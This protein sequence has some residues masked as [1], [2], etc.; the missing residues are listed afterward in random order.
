MISSSGGGIMPNQDVENYTDEDYI[1][2][3]R[4]IGWQYNLLYNNVPIVQNGNLLTNAS[5][6]YINEYVDNLTYIYGMQVPA[7]YKFFTM[8]ANGNDLQTPLVRGLDVYKI[9]NYLLG[10]GKDIID[11]LPKTLN[12]SAYSKGAISAKKDMMD[13]IKFQIENKAFLKIL[14][15][16]AG[17]DFKA[18]NRDFEN[19]EQVEKFFTDFQESM[20]IAYEQIA[21]HTVY[22]NDYKEKMSK[23]FAYTLI[24]NLGVIQVEYRNGQIHWDVVPCEEYIADYTKGK[25]VHKDDDFGGRI[26]QMTIPALLE[27]WEWTD[28][29]RKELEAMAD[30]NSTTSRLYAGTLAANNVFWW[31]NNN[32][33]PKVTVVEGQWISLERGEDGQIRE[34]LREGVLIGN[35]YLRGQKISQGQ[36]WR[37]GDKSR[38]RLKYIVMTPNLFMGTSIS[39]VGIIKRFANLKDAFI[40]KM[41]E[42]ASSAVGKATVVRASKLPEGLRAPDV[43]AQLK[44]ARVLVIEG[45]ETEENPNGARLAESVDL[46]LDPSIQ[47]ILGIVQYLDQ[48]INDY[49]NIPQSVRG[50]ASTYQSAKGIDATQTQSSKGLSFLFGTLQ[51]WMKEVLSY[52]ADVMKLMAPDD[53]MGM[54]SLSLIVGD[55]TAELLSMETVRKAQFEDFLLNLNPKDYMALT[56]KEKINNLLLQVGTSGMPLQIL[57]AYFSVSQAESLTEAE[58]KIDALIYK[59]EKKEAEKIAA[60]REMAM[61]QSQ[62]ASDTQRYQ[63]DVAA[64]AGLEK[65]AM[66]NETKQ[67]SLF[68][69]ANQGDRT[70]K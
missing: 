59:E 30:A 21:R 6:N 35:R 23:A 45:E 20:E 5:I 7:D 25:D 56:E 65:A 12:V 68:A 61:I 29:E 49:L 47:L 16:E 11:P 17:F 1:K 40:T 14:Q 4:W 26:R 39:V 10:E 37:A 55:G 66:E 32:G 62:Q 34:C 41:V 22:Y 27:R 28:S 51:E 63:A 43:I 52:S 58:N 50:M 31:T 60:E 57:K 19:N 67:L 8:D 70:M 53:E 36:V 69:K 48:A 46:T 44:Q 2:T 54:D 38:K 42:M 13:Y 9:Y 24:G 18:I 15:Q 3:L 33:V 64:N